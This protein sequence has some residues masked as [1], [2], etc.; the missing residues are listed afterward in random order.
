VKRRLRHVVVEVGPCSNCGLD[1]GNHSIE[2]ICILDIG[3]MAEPPSMYHGRE[4]YAFIDL[5]GAELN[6][7]V[8]TVVAAAFA[9]G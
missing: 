6:A 3:V 1:A 9:N 2:G 7:L 5:D 8:N 4:Q